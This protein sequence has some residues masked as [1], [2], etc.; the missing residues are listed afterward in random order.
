PDV[1]PVGSGAG[2]LDRSRRHAILDRAAV[3]G[4]AWATATCHARGGSTAGDIGSGA[5]HSGGGYRC[6]R[7]R[8]A[9]ARPGWV[10]AP[11]AS[12]PAALVPACGS[13][14]PAPVAGLD[15]GSARLR[16]ARRSGTNGSE[17]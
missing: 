7:G 4:G 3:A 17:R 8:R 11:F 9:R 5:L 6:G 1:R 15:A 13:A 14:G 2:D 10:A 12:D 16:A